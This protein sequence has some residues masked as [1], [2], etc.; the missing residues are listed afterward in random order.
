MT[1]PI[2]DSLAKLI[3]MAQQCGQHA[4][5][6]DRIPLDGVHRPLADLLTGHIDAAHAG[7]GTE[8]DEDG[9][10]RPSA[11]PAGAVQL[12]GQGAYRGE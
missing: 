6:P 10:R 1:R 2:L 5:T 8:G 11:L 12:I 4:P 7:L 3:G 9:V